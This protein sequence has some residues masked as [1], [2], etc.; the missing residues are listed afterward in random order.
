MDC[1]GGFRVMM[2]GLPGILEQ[3]SGAK[4]KYC[5]QDITNFYTI[6][7]DVIPEENFTNYCPQDDST[8]GIEISQEGAWTPA[9]LLPT[10]WLDASD[11]ATITENPTN[12]VQQWND[13]S[14]NG[15]HASQLTLANRPLTNQSGD[16]LFGFK[17]YVTFDTTAKRLINTAWNFTLTSQ[18]TFIV[19]RNTLAGRI[20]SQSNSGSDV[21]TGMYVPLVANNPT[22]TGSFMGSTTLRASVSRVTAPNVDLFISRHDGSTLTNHMRGSGG[23]DYVQS[24][25]ATVTR[26]GINTALNATNAYGNSATF[27]IGEI[28]VF[29]NINI[30]PAD[31]Q[32]MEGYLAHKW[33]FTF[34]LPFFHPYKTTPP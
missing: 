7:Y 12:T 2:F 20:F 17:N 4:L 25:N 16:P 18:H 32:K 8:F 24:L 33:N 6:D 23:V 9:L 5:P 30:S 34:L 1:G 11:T 3:L 31:V 27:D 29:N 13:K 19:F 22:P 21:A 28:V 14:G 15:Y 10:L 26:Y